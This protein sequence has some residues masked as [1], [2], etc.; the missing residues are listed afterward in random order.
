M[1]CSSQD[2]LTVDT[3]AGYDGGIVYY[4]APEG[5]GVSVTP[6]ELMAMDFSREKYLRLVGDMSLGGTSS[7][8]VSVSLSGSGEELRT[9]KV[10]DPNQVLTS[11]T[12]VWAASYEGGK[13]TGIT[14]GILKADGTV[15]FSEPVE[16]GAVLFF[17]DGENKPMCG[18]ILLQL[19]KTT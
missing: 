12:L 14:S 17:L 5:A 9:A 11:D 10:S 8:G 19:E 1:A 15:T 6:A 18:N 7:E 16:A 4:D 2:Q 3:P 13:M